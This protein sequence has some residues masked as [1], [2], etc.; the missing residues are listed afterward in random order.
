MRRIAIIP[1]RGGSKRIPRKNIK[2]FMGAPMISYPI[3]VALDS[4]LFDKV[5]VS[6]DDFEIA[7]IARKYGAEVPF[8]RSHENSDDYT[9]TGDVMY[10]VLRRYESENEIFDEACC[11]YA[12][13]PLLKVEHLLNTHDLL[14]SQ[15]YDSTFVVV[16]YDSPILRSYSVDEST[17]KAES[18]FP[19][20][21]KSG[22]RSQDIKRAF[23]DAGQ[24]Y[25]FF[26]EKLKR[27]SNKNLFG[28]KRGAIILDRMEVQDLD[29]SADWKMAEL[30]YK[31]TIS[32][33]DVD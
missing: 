13:S 4:G 14:L 2:L 27:L 17:G 25:W 5:M 26:P 21:E 23:S 31:Y 19:D 6:T 15:E 8:F 12:T 7:Q 18:N 30:K 28:E 16:E 24:H 3:K 22:K 9:G 29:T 33:S 1:A 11:I 20:T 32:S 10:E